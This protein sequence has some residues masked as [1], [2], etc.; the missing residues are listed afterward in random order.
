V[1]VIEFKDEKLKTL[2][3]RE[4]LVFRINPAPRKMM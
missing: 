4:T 3:A 2:F 1:W